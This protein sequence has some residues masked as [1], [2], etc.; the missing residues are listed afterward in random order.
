MAIKIQSGHKLSA[1]EKF[2]RLLLGD[3]MISGTFRFL[4]FIVLLLV[5]GNAVFR[6]LAA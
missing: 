4:V 6:L 5:I 2:E 3:N 1:R